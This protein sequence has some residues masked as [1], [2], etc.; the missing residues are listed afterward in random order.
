MSASR[1]CLASVAFSVARMTCPA[2]SLKRSVAAVSMSYNGGLNKPNVTT[3]D[4]RHLISNVDVELFSVNA[5]VDL[6]LHT[7]ASEWV[8]KNRQ[9]DK[10]TSTSS[11]STAF[12]WRSHLYPGFEAR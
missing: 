5:E 1:L 10:R 11:S 2:D 4:C 9:N 6:V 12:R 3:V 8:A 7:N